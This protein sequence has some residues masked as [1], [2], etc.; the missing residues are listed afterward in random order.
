MILLRRENSIPTIWWEVTSINSHACIHGDAFCLICFYHF[1]LKSSP[2]TSS[3]HSN[4]ILSLVGSRSTCWA[5]NMG[6][7]NSINYVHNS[8]WLWLDSHASCVYET[9]PIHLRIQHGL[10]YEPNPFDINTSVGT[11]RPIGQA[12]FTCTRGGLYRYNFDCQWSCMVHNHMDHT[13]LW[14]YPCVV[15]IGIFR[16]WVGLL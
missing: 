11:H 7:H 14:T 10:K 12:M 3:I 15:L 6:L 4:F 8:V 2:Y 9:S 5:K 1:L 16:N 13:L